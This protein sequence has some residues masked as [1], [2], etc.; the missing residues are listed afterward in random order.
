MVTCMWVWIVYANSNKI[1]LLFSHQVMSH[2]CV[3]LFCYLANWLHHQGPLF[4]G[5]QASILEWVGHFSSPKDLPNSGD[6]T[7]TSC[8]GRWILIH[9]TTREGQ[10]ENYRVQ[11]S[12]LKTS[13]STASWWVFL[14]N[15]SWACGHQAI[16]TLSR[17][18]CNL[19]PTQ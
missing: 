5:S 4:I 14:L 12:Y 1:V 2:S 9:W 8:I 15:F 10:Q 17:F 18:R 6:W 7:C 3:Q 16:I 11:L 19:N 13:N